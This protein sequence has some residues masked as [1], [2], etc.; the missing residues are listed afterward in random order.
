MGNM[1][2]LRRDRPW[3]KPYLIPLFVLAV[4]ALL[5]TAVMLLWNAIIPGITGWAQ[6]TWP[7]AVGLLVLCRLLFGGFKG[8][9][10]AGGWHRWRSPVDDDGPE[11][12]E[13]W[14]ARCKGMSD[15]QRQRLKEEWSRRCGG[16]RGRSRRWTELLPSPVHAIHEGRVDVLHRSLER[17]RMQRRQAD[18]QTSGR[19]TNERPSP[20]GLRTRME[21]RARISSPASEARNMLHKRMGVEVRG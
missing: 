8:K 14:R 18:P 20:I 21:R 19:A 12:T 1:N 16:F 9:P 3:R 15:E 11:A 2:E 10:G 13:G 7:Q 6:L 5:G 4:V 17:S